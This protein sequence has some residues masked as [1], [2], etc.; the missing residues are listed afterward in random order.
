MSAQTER[1]RIMRRMAEIA[2]LP[3]ITQADGEEFERLDAAYEAIAGPADAEFAEELRRGLYRAAAR[4]DMLTRP[5]TSA[6]ITSATITL[7][8]AAV[9][10]ILAVTVDHH[11]AAGPFIFLGAFFPAFT[12]ACWPLYALL[13]RTR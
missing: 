2:D 4:R 9:G 13:E 12:L 8:G 10:L 6:A 11:V 7:F 5:L 3:T 1:D